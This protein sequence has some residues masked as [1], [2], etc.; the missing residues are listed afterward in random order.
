MYH[1]E[2]LSRSRSLPPRPHL[3]EP[4]ADVA[5]EPAAAVG[6]DAADGDGRGCRHRRAF[7]QRRHPK[8]V[9]P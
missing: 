3:Y 5:A 1:H 7:L 8:P 2:H 9:T 6:A 4:A